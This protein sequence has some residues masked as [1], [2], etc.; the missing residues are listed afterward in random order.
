MDRVEEGQML[1]ILQHL[2]NEMNIFSRNMNNEER[3]SEW[4]RLQFESFKKP[5]PDDNET[6]EAQAML[7]IIPSDPALRY[8]FLAKAFILSMVLPFPFL[9]SFLFPFCFPL[10]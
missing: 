6:A 9:F 8:E 1:Q 10:S 2:M 7:D 5:L 4:N 3:M